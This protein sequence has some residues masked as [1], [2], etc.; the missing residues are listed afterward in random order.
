M[1]LWARLKRTRDSEWQQEHAEIGTLT[2]V[3]GSYNRAA[4]LRCH[5]AVPLEDRHNLAK[6]PSNRTPRSLPKRKEDTSVQT[7]K[8][9]C[10]AALFIVVKPGNH[11]STDRFTSGVQHIQKAESPG[12]KKKHNNAHAPAPKHFTNGKRGCSNTWSMLIGRGRR[13]L[14][15]CLGLGWRQMAADTTHGGDRNVL[16]PGYGDNY[17]AL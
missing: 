6:W 11:P 1:P 5:L 2:V 14:S 4:R 16:T 9:M 12:N 7:S 15:F 3:N 13:Q 8:R 17:I 10:I